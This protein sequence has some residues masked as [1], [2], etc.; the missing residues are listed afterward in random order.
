MYTP[1]YFQAIGV[2]NNNYI[3]ID[4]VTRTHIDFW[5]GFAVL[6]GMCTEFMFI[7]SLKIVSWILES[8]FNL[9]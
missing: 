8:D 7:I 3:K 6:E 4:I 2:E 9:L 5:C 1:K